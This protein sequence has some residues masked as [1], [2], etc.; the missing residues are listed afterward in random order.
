M[1]SNCQQDLP[2]PGK[3][4]ERAL[5]G[6]TRMMTFEAEAGRLRLEGLALRAFLEISE[7]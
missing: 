1:T 6:L 7:R 2:S 4:L 3:P 5:L